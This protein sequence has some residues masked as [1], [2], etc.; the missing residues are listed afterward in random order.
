MPSEPRPGIGAARS[1]AARWRAALDGALE[2]G[3]LEGGALDGGAQPTS[4]MG[5]PSG[6]GAV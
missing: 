1:T 2:G 5:S 4:S 3:A 6:S